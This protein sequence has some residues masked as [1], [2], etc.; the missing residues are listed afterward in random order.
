VSGLSLVEYVRERRRAD[1]VVCKLPD[2]IRQQISTAADKKIK[3]AV[4]IAWLQEEQSVRISED[5]LTV[6]ANAR[7]DRG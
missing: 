6:H 7:H 5:E 3:R 2:E 4:V 1:C